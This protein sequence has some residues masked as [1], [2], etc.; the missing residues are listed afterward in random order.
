MIAVV[1]YGMGN[2][3]SVMNALEAIG[4]DATLVAEPAHIEG[5]KGILL[6]GVGAF[7]EGMA[8]LHRLGM[9]ESIKEAVQTGRPLLGICLGMQ[10]LADAGSEHGIHEGLGLIAGQ[11]K[12]LQPLPEKRLRLPHI[13]WNDL[14]CEKREGLF[15]GL[16]EVEAFYF[17]HSFVFHPKDVAVTAGTTE[18]GEEFVSAIEQDNVWAAQF[19]PEKSHKAGMTL[20]RNWVDRVSSC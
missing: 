14:R 16:R 5:A 10:L 12:Q 3:G 2:L 7:G 13:G 17:V 11:V 15:K 9:V 6:P 20:L 18:Y 4:A 19:H 1:N 8:N